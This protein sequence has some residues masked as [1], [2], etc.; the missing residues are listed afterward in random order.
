[1]SFPQ[2]PCPEEI[3]KYQYSRSITD[4]YLDLHIRKHAYINK[5]LCQHIPIA[6]IW[7]DGGNKWGLPCRRRG[8]D[9]DVAADERKG[10]LIAVR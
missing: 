3:K 6:S 7:G 5:R 9:N 4:Q 10:T 8:T 2:S 1:M